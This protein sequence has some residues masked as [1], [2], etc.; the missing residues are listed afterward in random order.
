MIN[1]AICDDDIIQLRILE[2]MLTTLSFSDEQIQV[3]SFNSGDSLI[4]EIERGITYEIYL[5]DMIMPFVSGLEIART[6][7]K[8]D[9]TAQILFLT[10]SRDYA[11]DSY[12]VN[13][14]SYLLKPFSKDLLDHEIKK[15]IL[16][17]KPQEDSYILIR[18]KGTL[19]KVFLTNIVYAEVRLDKLYFF[20]RNGECMITTGTM[21][22]LENIL[23]D[24]E[25]FFKVHR[26]F[27]VNMEYIKRLNTAN[28]EM[29]I[30]ST[31]IPLS[32]TVR[33]TFREDY[34]TY[35]T[36]KANGVRIL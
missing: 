28:I 11:I 10:S 16:N 13:A 25:S 19:Q 32:R 30:Y 27:I 1:I 9:S 35:V 20:L 22:E 8:Q 24:K 33:T 31:V 14:A 23:R 18:Q 29:N 36:N 15:A 6:I 26:S 4:N 17:C 2:K 7:R 12:E 21:Y 3:K 5:L 34:I